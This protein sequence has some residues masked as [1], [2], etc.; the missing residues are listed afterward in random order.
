[1]ALFEHP[2]KLT[3]PICREIDVKQADCF[4]YDIT[5]LEILVAEGNPKFFSITLRGVKKLAKSNPNFDPYRAVYSSLPDAAKANP[6]ARQQY[7]NGQ[8]CY[9]VRA[10]IATNGLGIC[11]H[12]AFFDDDFRI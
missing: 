5:G 3:E 7:I 11:R 2:V 9:A 8:F 6:G 12:I 10:G 4:I 1:M